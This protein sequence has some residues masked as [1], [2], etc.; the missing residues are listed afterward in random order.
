MVSSQLTT[1]FKLL[2]LI[3]VFASL[4]ALLV[5][6]AD[7]PSEERFWVRGIP[8][9]KQVKS[10]FFHGKSSPIFQLAR[11]LRLLVFRQERNRS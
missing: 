11:V 10:A 2:W 7:K 8:E 1:S 3:A 4:N 5:A 6:A 9:S